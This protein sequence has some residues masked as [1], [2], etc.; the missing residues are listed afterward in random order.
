[1]TGVQ[2]FKWF[3]KEQKI[4]PLIRQL[5]YT[6]R[7]TDNGWRNYP[8]YLSFDEYIG[9]MISSYGFVDL[10]IRLENA[11]YYK[12][13]WNKYDEFSKQHELPNLNKKWHYFVYHNIFIDEDVLKV[14]SEVEYRRPLWDA[15]EDADD[16][17]RAIV[18]TIHPDGFSVRIDS[19]V[20]NSL[21]NFF[22]SI[23]NLRDVNTH[24][25]LKINFYIKRNRRKYYGAD[26]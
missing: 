11:Y 20:D 18:R 19:L 14:G 13:G 25:P 15:R 3:C 12:I 16:H 23:S 4:M 21:R 8:T 5:Y 7:P 10:M 17:E 1:M 9:K 24:E 26:R 6:I 22:Y 2:V